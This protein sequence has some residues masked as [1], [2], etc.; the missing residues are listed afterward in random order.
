M[1]LSHEEN[2]ITPKHKRLV[3]H[4]IREKKKKKDQ[5]HILISLISLQMENGPRDFWAW[6]QIKLMP[7]HPSQ[8]KIN[9]YT[10]GKIWQTHKYP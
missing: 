8:W 2:Y 9:T 1:L 3:F 4:K 7:I 5:A 6:H 10:L